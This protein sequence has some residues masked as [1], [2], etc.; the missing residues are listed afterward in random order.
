VLVC[1]EFWKPVLSSLKGDSKMETFVKAK[2]T[3]KRAEEIVKK[4]FG[5][6]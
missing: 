2:L 3:A 5:E 1:F 6:M 4:M